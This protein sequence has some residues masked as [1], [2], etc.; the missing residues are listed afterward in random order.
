MCAVRLQHEITHALLCGGIVNR[1][2]QREAT[3]L[4]MGGELARRERDVLSP[5]RRVWEPSYFWATSLR[6]QRRIVSGVTIRDTSAR[7][8]RPRTMPS[9]PGGAAGR[10]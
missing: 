3:P 2:Q 10:R 7:R 9:Q 8:P 4:T 6:Y 5:G 1:T